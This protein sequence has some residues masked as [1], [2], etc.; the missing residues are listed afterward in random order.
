MNFH[1][2]S[3]QMISI[4]LVRVTQLTIPVKNGVEEVDVEL[5]SEHL[6]GKMGQQRQQDIGQV[7]RI[8]P[9]TYKI[10]NYF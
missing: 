6:G 10:F 2:K 9:T 8:A 3:L 1:K 4:A 5:L 7:T